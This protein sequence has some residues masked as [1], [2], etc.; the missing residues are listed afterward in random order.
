MTELESGEMDEENINW[1]VLFLRVFAIV[2]LVGII[3]C[4]GIGTISERSYILAGICAI[5]LVIFLV[6]SFFKL[7]ICS[8]FSSRYVQRSDRFGNSEV[9]NPMQG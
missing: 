1:C 3:I 5:C 6:I 9:R 8:L 7:Q 4:V 2:L